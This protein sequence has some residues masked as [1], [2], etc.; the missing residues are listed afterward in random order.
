M[1]DEQQKQGEQ[2]EHYWENFR[3]S[4]PEDERP[5]AD[6]YSAWYFCDNQADA[7]ELAELVLSGV[8]RATA[9]LVWAYEEEGETIPQAGEYSIITRWDGEPVCIIQATQV[10]IVAFDD[11]GEEF[12]RTEGEGDGSLAYWRRVHWEAF[13]RECASIG[14][15]PSRDMP[16]CCEKFRVV[17]PR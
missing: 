14:L 15:I 5:A 17:Y 8:K 3:S 6:R 1:A 13:E 11:V 4:L 10:E 2:L 9:G 16:V 12:A 7:D